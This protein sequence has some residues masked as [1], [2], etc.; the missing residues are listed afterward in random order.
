M[1]ADVLKASS[2]GIIIYEPSRLSSKLEQLLL[3][4]PRWPESQVPARTTGRVIIGVQTIHKRDIQTLNIRTNIISLVVYVRQVGAIL[5][6]HSIGPFS[7]R[8]LVSGSYHALCPVYMMPDM[9]RNRDH[10]SHAD[11]IKEAKA[12]IERLRKRIQRHYDVTSGQFLKV[13]YGAP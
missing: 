8:S 4:L 11:G 5:Q 1:S 12:G 6:E 3:L 9:N 13:W 2:P 7:S 10:V